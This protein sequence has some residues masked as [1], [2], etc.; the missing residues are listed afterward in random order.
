MGS[1]SRARSHSFGGFVLSYRKPLTAILIAITVFFAY[2]AAHVPIATRFE[3]LFPS[4][5]PD[6]LLYRQYR[7]QYGGAQTLVL[8]LRVRN[9]DIFNMKTLSA[10]Q[11]ITRKVDILPGVN[12][13]E[14][15]SLASYRVIYARAIPG[16][17]VSR[18]YMYPK[19]PKDQAEVDEL[20]QTVMTHR[21][22]LAGY[23]TH[24]LKGA[25]IIAA[26][27]E[28][29]LDYKALFDSVQQ[30]IN[31]HEDS[32]TT[33]YASGPVMFAAW[34]YHYLPRIGL[35]I[36]ISIALM[37]FILYVSLG[38]RSGWWAPIITGLC[39]TIWGL[40]FVGLMRFNFDPIML[41]IPFILTARDLS[42]GIQWHGRYYD[43]LDRLDDKMTACA[44]T[45]DLM[46]RPGILAVLANV[47]GVVFLAIGDIPLLKQIGYGGAV[48]LGAS[49][50]MVFVFQPILMSYLAK[51]EIYSWRLRA[52]E[53]PKRDAPQAGWLARIPVMP[54][55]LRAG[56]IIAGTA[57]MIFG[58]VESSRVPIGYQTPGTPI[59]RQDAKI[60]Q[61]TAEI[62]KFV[63]TDMAWVVIEAP[64]FPKPQNPIATQTLRMSDDLASYLMSRGDA[65]AV[66]GFAEIATKPMNML[67][68]NGD[69]K[70]LAIPDTD[71]LSGTLWFF[72][73]SG[74]APDEVYTFF[75][76]YPS[77]TS[78]SIRLLLPDHTYPRL[79][80]LE[81]DLNTFMKERVANDPHLTQVKVRYVGGDAGLYLA[82]DNVVG[83]LNWVNVVLTLAVIFVASALIF[84]SPVAGL[85]FLIAAVMANFVAFIYMKYQ[86]IGLT[87]DTIPVISIGIGL[88]INYA[89]YIVGRIRD[90]V[91]SG[92]QLNNAI[93][94]SLRT[95][96]K[97]VF[98]T[99]AVM[100]GGILP[101]VFSPL[102]FH[103]EM[104]VLLMLLM[105]ANLIVG[106]F[107]L[108]GYIAW[109]RPRF[110][111]RYALE[112]T[113][114]SQRAA[115]GGAAR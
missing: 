89:I 70:Y 42:H 33:I 8:M 95:T 102:L 96:G 17:L 20:R 94:T 41:V 64:N 105:L 5:D 46:L 78:M 2:W 6:V 81:A 69:P 101:W 100:I 34:G 45:A 43:E 65:L 1:D 57:L 62:G 16:A 109:R 97:W 14:V 93:T 88:G 18:P 60:N 23:V 26:F 84:T 32:N 115:A 48:W 107:I 74:S 75:G 77:V 52:G 9:G 11:D 110:L 71:A 13:N 91:A 113:A 86:V 92:V 87:V 99:F 79:Q 66:L 90:E 53:S 10:I 39:S 44:A 30:L 56:L 63:P 35:I 67:L 80:R 61:D 51:P 55:G 106:L 12:H 7:R 49:L 29:G 58:I 111:T 73:F 47:A 104:S 37:L 24:D 98:A 25:M 112:R 3:D 50:A 21:D 27:N 4:K 114:E 38:R 85:L 19:L 15:F 59:Y 83:R 68:H 40:G 76:R 108:P 28:G 31:Q 36:L 72:F 103:N 54:G 82:A 22:E